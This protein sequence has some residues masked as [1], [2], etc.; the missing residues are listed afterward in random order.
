[1]KQ[2]TIASLFFVGLIVAA[3]AIAQPEP[4]PAPQAVT[5]NRVWRK[6]TD[7][8][9]GGHFAFF[10]DRDKMR[11][12]DAA[13]VK[14]FK[15]DPSVIGTQAKAITL[16]I[17]W[18]KSLAFPMYLND[19]YG[20]CYYAAGC[21]AD[22][23]WTG[24]A[25]VKSE[26]SL[27]AIKN[28]YF[29]LSGGDNGLTDSD[30][31]GEMMNRYLADVQ[32]AKIVSWFSIETTDPATV[33]DCLFHFGVVMFTLATPNSWINN[34]NTGATWDVPAVANRNNGHAVIFNGVDTRGYYKVQTWG[35]F[36]WLTPAG[37]RACD[38]GGWVCFSARW[39]NPAT[40][41]A[42]NGLHI[43][44]LAKLWQARSG[45]TIPASVIAAFPPPGVDPPAPAPS[46]L[47]SITLSGNLP[48]GTYQLHP[49]GAVVVNPATTI[50]QLIDMLNSGPPATVPGPAIDNGHPDLKQLPPESS[51]PARQDWKAFADFRELTQKRLD[52]HER[53]LK[54]TLDLLE[55]M[56]KVIGKSAP[57]STNP[58][59]QPR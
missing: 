15:L 46:V 58:S 51:S 40:G 20:S 2:F 12:K 8:P 42:P 1:M 5:T 6:K 29:A 30:M 19:Q 55:S 34:S 35:T 47:P 39:F 32:D 41:R 36:V 25:T 24:N 21:H 27:A 10:M 18:A 44:E 7:H 4:A 33:Q 31:Q 43:T 56:Q 52:D 59:V 45:K 49:K 38:P 54:R 17:D 13:N 26:F 53:H 14:P 23:T 28:R 16:P 22:N 37:V 3:T 57:Q 50:R 9:T 11:G 48:A